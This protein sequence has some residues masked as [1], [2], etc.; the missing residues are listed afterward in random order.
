MNNLDRIIEELQ[1]YKRPREALY[2]ECVN[3][4]LNESVSVYYKELTNSIDYLSRKDSKRVMK[5]INKDI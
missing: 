4:R 1:L 3:R 5:R 2:A